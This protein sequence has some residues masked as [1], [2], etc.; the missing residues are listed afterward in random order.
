MDRRAV[1]PYPGLR[2]FSREESPF[3]FGR[4]R[5]VRQVLDRLT[6]HHFVAIV[7]RSGCGKSSLVRAGL[8]PVLDAGEQLGRP[9]LVAIMRPGHDP[10]NALADAVSHA[11][12]HQHFDEGE[13]ADGSN[14]QT[15]LRLL[16]DEARRRD[17]SYTLVVDQFEEIFRYV[18]RSGL[19]ADHARVFVAA[20]LDARSSQCRV[21]ITMRA[22]FLGECSRFDGLL[23]ALNVSQYLLPPLSRAELREAVEGPARISG[24][25]VED[26]LLERV[27]N[28]LADDPD[29]LPLMQHTL[30]RLWRYAVSKGAAA[31]TLTSD[32]YE[33][34]GTVTRSLA[35]EAE[36][37]YL[38]LDVRQRQIAE[39]VFRLVTEKDAA[40]FVVRR[41]VRI[42]K[43]SL[44]TG[45][46]V[47]EVARML[48]PFSNP[49]RNLLVAIG[50]PAGLAPYTI[51][52][53]SHEVLLR[54]WDRL[55]TWIDR[56]TESAT[57]YRHLVNAAKQWEQGGASLTGAA[58]RTAVDWAAQEQP[59]AAWASRY[60]PA[61]SFDLV[62]SLVE[63][64]QRQVGAHASPKVRRNDKIF[65]SY[66]R[67]DSS[68][69]AARINER[70][71][72]RFGEDRI[73][74]DVDTIPSGA[75][76]RRFIT[77]K[78]QECGVCLVIIGDHWTDARGRGGTDEGQR[79]L[80][81]PDDL[82]RREIEVALHT[83]LRVIPVLVGSAPMPNEDEL[84]DSIGQLVHFQAAELRAGP[85]FRQ[86]LDKLVADIEEAV[87]DGPN[88][89]R[90][91]QR[92]RRLV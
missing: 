28:D 34:V 80:D 83:H 91:W 1:N 24:A 39:S 36:E 49:D 65:L 47:D 70:L 2:P 13:R 68:H 51:V 64:S 31:P 37:A 15:L 71:V 74:Y 26:S 16:G 60:A 41:P 23:D 3:F 9:P 33:A 90:L 21:V 18:S 66:R 76:F 75:D 17:V 88:A 69:A 79:R 59:A 78:L 19:E 58:L 4:Q 72:D 55:T 54:R 12:A 61:D 84:P 81:N 73:F 57:L 52:D 53:I 63:Q 10:V 11:L 48:A 14:P 35:L 67:E 45:A 82:V 43:I 38:E 85:E 20:L 6:S 89:R 40:G 46:S 5:S 27:L 25:G 62:M 32:G 50:P 44:V 29:Q 7:G 42:D 86:R 22:D 92:L 87:G 77:S 30:H 8:F 56:E